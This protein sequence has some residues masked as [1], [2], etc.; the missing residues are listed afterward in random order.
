MKK[1]YFIIGLLIF[2]SLVFAQSS[3]PVQYSKAKKTSPVEKTEFR[4]KQRELYNHWFVELNAGTNKASAPFAEGYYAS[5]PNRFSNFGTINH[6]GLG[7]RYMAS[8]IFGVKVGG[9]YDIIQNLAGTNSKDFK[10]TL[11]TVTFEGVLNLGRLARFETFTNRL[12]LLAH[13]G[14]QT[15]YKMVDFREGIDPGSS[16]SSE[17]DGGIV[18]GISPI[19]KI[20]KRISIVGDFSS[21][22]NFRQHINWDGSKNK[23]KNL[24][25]S[26]YNTTLG[27]IVAL[28]KSERESADWYIVPIE[29]QQ[30]TDAL[31]RLEEVEAMTNDTDRDGI[32]DYRDE[33]NNTPSGVAVDNKGRYMDRNNNGVS[34]DLEGKVVSGNNTGVAGND[35]SPSNNSVAAVNNTSS[36]SSEISGDVTD[37]LIKNGY[38]NIFF[39]INSDQPNQGS[40]ANVYHIIQYLKS[41]PNTK[42]KLI[43]HADPTGDMAANKELSERRAKSLF[44]LIKASGVDGSRIRIEGVGEDKLF[45]SSTASGNN[46]SRRVTVVLE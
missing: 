38:L 30:V 35:V 46:I 45:S 10:V 17:Q 20:S 37:Q 24:N 44:N 5:D 32:P 1:N 39:N 7:I 3:T 23:D 41:N 31:K 42:V 13:A 22:S 12:N 25:G 40:S 9:G 6:Y 8:N 15:T 33:Q 28:G 43:G 18:F 29:N 21:F 2:T 11:Y 16:A 26:I 34:D 4:N 36:S 14:V 19:Y 27:L